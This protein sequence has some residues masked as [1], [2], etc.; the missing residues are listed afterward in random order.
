MILT[1]RFQVP[2]GLLSSPNRG[3]CRLILHRLL[4]RP[5]GMAEARRL[6]DLDLAG[7]FERGLTA[8]AAPV[9]WL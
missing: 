3:A 7:D 1:E 2:G 8:T 4:G 6:R 9:R 5:F